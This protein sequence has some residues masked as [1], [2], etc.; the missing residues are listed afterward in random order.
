MENLILN[1]KYFLIT[2][3][4]TDYKH[5]IK[6][7]LTLQRECS[8]RKIKHSRLVQK[9]VPRILNEKSKFLNIRF[10]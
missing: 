1:V 8:I 5:Y 10:T 7:T 6:Y 4:D 9:V 2:S 3:S